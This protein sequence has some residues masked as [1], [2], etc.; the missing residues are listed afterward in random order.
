ME[1]AGFLIDFSD[2][3]Y[4]DFLGHIATKNENF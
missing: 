1:L 4:L 2:H 3:G